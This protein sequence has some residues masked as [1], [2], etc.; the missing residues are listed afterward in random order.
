M[1]AVVSCAD[2]DCLVC[3]GCLCCALALA[4]SNVCFVQAFG[5]TADS[6]S[7]SSAKCTLFCKHN[8][9]QSIADSKTLHINEKMFSF[10][11]AVSKAAN[12]CLLYEIVITDT[13]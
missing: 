6:C 1:S 12:E 7:L 3:L 8:N 13:D 10:A 4:I 5:I 11:G 2:D 9:N